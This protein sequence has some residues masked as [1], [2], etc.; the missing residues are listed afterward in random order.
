MTSIRKTHHFPIT[1]THTND[2]NQIFATNVYQVCERSRPAI[3]ISYIILSSSVSPYR[4][5]DNIITSSIMSL[6]FRTKWVKFQKYSR[7]ASHVISVS[8]AFKIWDPTIFGLT[9]TN[10]F[11]SSR[12]WRRMRKILNH[13][14]L[15]SWIFLAAC[16]FWWK[17]FGD[18]SQPVACPV[19]LIA[20]FFG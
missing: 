12:Q 5:V 16:E 11:I 20:F 7:D 9:I 6:L 15:D 13:F 3:I 1:H 19:K 2:I 10:R 14:V 17:S 4:H 18:Y 8:L